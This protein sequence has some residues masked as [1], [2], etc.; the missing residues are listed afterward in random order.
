MHLRSGLPRQGS[1]AV[2]HV[3]V[4]EYDEPAMCATEELSITLISS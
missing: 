1:R 4:A 2:Y 3:A